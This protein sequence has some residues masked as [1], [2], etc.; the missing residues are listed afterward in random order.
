MKLLEKLVIAIVGA[1][2]IY[3]LLILVQLLPH[4]LVW[5]GTIE[6]LSLLYWME[7]F[8][9]L[10]MVFL[11]LI[12]LMKNGTI[13]S[14]FKDTTLRRILL[15]FAVFFGLN[16]VGNLFAEFTAEKVQAVVTLFL[17]ITLFRLSRR[18]QS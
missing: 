7:G 2:S 3:H 14:R 13:K 6:S 9:L 18:P 16:T 1:Y 10:T 8:A 11:G 12:L 5:G 15:V 17:A 4:H